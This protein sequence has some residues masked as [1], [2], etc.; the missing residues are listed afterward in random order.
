MSSGV[1]I[2]TVISS[3]ELVVKKPQGPYNAAP[4]MQR[5]LLGTV[6]PAPHH[7]RLVAHLA[8]PLT[9][10]PVNIGTKRPMDIHAI[11]PEEMK[12]IM[13]VTALWL[14]VREGLGLS[15]VKARRQE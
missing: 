14:I 15:G 2:D 11:S 5:I 4:T 10:S 7:P 3:C 1:L 6:T 8:I 12:D 9:L 13:T